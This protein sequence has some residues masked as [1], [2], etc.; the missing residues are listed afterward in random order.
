MLL[1]LAALLADTATTPDLTN[2]GTY[3]VQLPLAAAVTAFFVFFVNRPKD[4]MIDQLQAD[5]KADAA[6]AATALATAQTQAATEVT[7]ARSE[8]RR[9][10]EERAQQS[11]DLMLQMVPRLQQ[12]V[13]TLQATGQ[14]LEGALK[15]QPSPS[16]ELI[17]QLRALR[18]EVQDLRA[19]KDGKV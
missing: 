7:Q 18:A 2:P 15:Q 17:E 14:G 3:L 11:R 13:S 9:L 6:A 1:V 16:D 4:R 5:R 8:I 12:T 19:A 10:N